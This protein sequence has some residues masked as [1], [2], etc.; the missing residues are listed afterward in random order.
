[1]RGLLER[2]QRWLRPAETTASETTA[3]LEIVRRLTDLPVRN[4][5]LYEQ[6]LTH[7]SVLRGR[8][9]STCTRTSGWNFWATP[10]W[11]SSWRPISTNISR[12]ATRAS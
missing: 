11:D 2:L 3:T 9:D 7:R 6:A 8:P 5:A 4:A 12:I 1:M 10:C